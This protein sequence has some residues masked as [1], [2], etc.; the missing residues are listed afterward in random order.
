[1]GWLSKLAGL[2]DHLKL[3]VLMKFDILSGQGVA[4][5]RWIVMR[6]HASLSDEQCRVALVTLLYA[7]TLVNNNETRVE[8]FARMASAARRVLEGDGKLTFEP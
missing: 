2:T 3:D 7:R 6:P 8:L 5:L 4:A 1:M